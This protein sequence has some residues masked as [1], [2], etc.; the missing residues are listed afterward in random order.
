MSTGIRAV[1]WIGVGAFVLDLKS[2]ALA[3]FQLSMDSMLR[4]C[5]RQELRED[6]KKGVYVENISEFEVQ[7]VSDIIRLL[8]QRSCTWVQLRF[9]ETSVQVF[10]LKN[11]Y[12][13]ETS[14]L[15]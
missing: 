1:L 8:T 14:S 7:S 12:L 9:G 5:A 15:S 2:L 6:V 4:C 3:F 10:G 13:G 11:L